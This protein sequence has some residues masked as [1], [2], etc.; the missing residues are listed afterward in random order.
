MARFP[1]IGLSKPVV[2]KYK[3]VRQKDCL[4]LKFNGGNND[5][6]STF[7]N[8]HLGEVNFERPKM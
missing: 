8:D 1:C 7:P 4:S 3:C 2:Y 5:N 6:M